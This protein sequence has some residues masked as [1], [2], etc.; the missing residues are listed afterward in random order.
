M[1]AGSDIFNFTKSIKMVYIYCV[2]SYICT[3]I[4]ITKFADIIPQ[5]HGVTHVSEVAVV[6]ALTHWGRV[7][8]ICVSN[9]TIIGSDNGLSI[10]WCQAIIWTS[11][12]NIVDWTLGILRNKLQWNLKQTCHSKIWKTRRSLVKKQEIWPKTRRLYQTNFAVFFISN[13]VS[14]P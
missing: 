11:D 12:G 10:D 1:I 13:C 2:H 7:T 14:F 9:V 5:W 6:I 3:C 8:H 4:Q